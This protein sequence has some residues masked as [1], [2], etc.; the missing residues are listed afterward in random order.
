MLR[1]GFRRLDDGA[2]LAVSLAV[3]VALRRPSAAS[4]SWWT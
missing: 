3:G 4:A 2:A 1:A